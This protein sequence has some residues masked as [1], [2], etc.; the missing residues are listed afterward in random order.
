MKN[1][2]AIGVL[3][4][5]FGTTITFAQ[6]TNVNQGS[7]MNNK[8]LVKQKFEQWENGTGT[9]FDLLDENVEW[10]MRG[11]SPISGVWKS[12]Q[13][14]SSRVVDPINRKLKTRLFPKLLNIYQ[15]GDVLTVLWEGKATAK[16]GTSYKNS[17]CWIL[18]MK[19]A[20]IVKINAY[21]VLS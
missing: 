8:D 1:V 4:I 16:D 21:L 20:K 13:Q 14:Y 19:N 15:E 12:K 6:N 7:T 18:E 2:L 9:I 3:L 11:T 5:F 10:I 17:Y